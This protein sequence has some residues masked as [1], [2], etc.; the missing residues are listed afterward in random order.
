MLLMCSFLACDVTC[1]LEGA[2][3]L[4]TVCDVD[5][6]DPDGTV[7]ISHCNTWRAA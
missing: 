7:F 1:V 4:M 2:H 5:F 3:T 6:G